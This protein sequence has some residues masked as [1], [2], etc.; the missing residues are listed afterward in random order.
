MDQF[1]QMLYKA[2]GPEQLHGG[3]FSTLAV[4]NADEHAAALDDGWCETTPQALEAQKAAADAD[5][6]AAKLAE[7]AA[8]SAAPTREQLEKQ[9]TDLGVEFS[10][11]IGDKKLAERIAAKLAE[12]NAGA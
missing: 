3:S 7:Q 6:D 8:V 5:A 1:P 10:P 12:Q 4:H 11:N 9:A 2:G